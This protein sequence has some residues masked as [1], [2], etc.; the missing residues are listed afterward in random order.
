MIA[1]RA[2]T[3]LAIL[4]CLC[5]SASV[6]PAD[7]SAQA[8]QV[9]K[10][11]PKKANKAADK[12]KA[13]YT[14]RD[15]RLALDNYSQAV[16]LDPDNPNHL[17]WRG[18]MHFY[19]DQHSQ[20]VP[21]LE[22]ALAKGYKDPL[23]VYT[24]RWRSYLAEKNFDSAL[25]DVRKGT[26]LE[27]NNL[28]FLRALG[29]ISAAKGDHRSAV[30]AYQRILAKN[31]NTNDL[32]IEIARAN[33]KIGDT[34]GQI[35]AAEEAIKRG[36]PAMSEARMLLV[37]GYRKQRKYDQAIDYY[38]KVVEASPDDYAAYQNLADL[39]RNQ[40]RFNDAIDVL[41]KALRRF[42]ND[43]RI[44]T[45][46]GALYSLADRNEEAV[47]AAQA[48]IRFLPNEHLSYTN[49][50][51][52]YND[53]NKPEMAIRECNNALKISAEDGETYFYLAR[54]NDL[55][56]KPNEATQYYKRA[57]TGLVEFTK[58]NPDSAYGYYL[59]GN[60]YFADNQREKAIEAYEK[61]LEISPRFG[62]ARYNV[63]IIQLR[64]R[65][66]T[67]ALEQYNRL[68]ELDPELAGKLKI[69]IDKS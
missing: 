29:D 51:R 30:D 11:D 48:G 6:L 42:P 50:C 39:L 46:L 66:K 15:F 54:A 26:E 65:N 21:D 10:K 52:A 35:S 43:G 9:V 28:D 33:S 8:K 38:Y 18:A 64:Q 32:Y 14:K 5:L 61:C 49:L 53:V 44:Y 24:I 41:R 63:A 69:E 19:L 27:P 2:F 62:R 37:D 34:D 16:E 17:F 55:A 57:V 31:P 20:A 12:G 23:K 4:G 36:T 68:L 3:I 47:Q 67:A 22:N 56:G 40:N 45:T 25:A 58:K 7:V 13:A 1:N 59:L 60:A